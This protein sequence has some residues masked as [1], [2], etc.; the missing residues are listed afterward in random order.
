MVP[1]EVAPEDVEAAARVVDPCALTVVSAVILPLIV[2]KNRMEP[3][4]VMAEAVGSGPGHAEVGEV[5]QNCQLDGSTA[6]STGHW[7][8]I[9][10]SGATCRPD[11]RTD[12][13]E[14]YVVY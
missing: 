1:A 4:A 6:R 2:R 12:P 14:R 7:T 9:G 10:A 8:E 11:S 13:G 3:V 5:P